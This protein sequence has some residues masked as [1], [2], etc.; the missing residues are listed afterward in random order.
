[1]HALNFYYPFL[2]LLSTFY[3]LAAWVDFNQTAKALSGNILH[4][5]SNNSH[6]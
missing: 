5:K 1:M 2:P 6:M 3:K 4:P